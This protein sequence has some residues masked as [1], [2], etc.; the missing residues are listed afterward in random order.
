MATTKT[1]TARD[2]QDEQ[3]LRFISKIFERN[4]IVVRRENLSRG[5][6]FRVKSGDCLHDGKQVL[7]VDKRLPLQQQLSVM[8]DYLLDFNFPLSDDEVSSLPS[9]VQQ[10][11]RARS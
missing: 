6:S 1:S 9:Q 5:H 10:M 4:E 7:F 11:V 3:Q 8:L 2:K